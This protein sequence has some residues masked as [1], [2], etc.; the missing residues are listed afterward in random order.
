MVGSWKSIKYVLRNVIHR[1]KCIS[2]ASSWWLDNALFGLLMLCTFDI[3]FRD[4]FVWC[5]G[6]LHSYIHSRVLNWLLGRFIDVVSW[7]SR[8]LIILEYILNAFRAWLNQVLIY[9]T[10]DVFK[11][12]NISQWAHDAIITSSLRQN[13]VGEVMKTLSLRHVSVGMR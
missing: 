8:C 13:E 10:Q 6:R 3:C 11:Y 5:P 4:V 1:F 7:C 12:L 9:C 2:T